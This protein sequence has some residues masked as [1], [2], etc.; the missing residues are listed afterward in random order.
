L[1]ALASEV[2]YLI[3]TLPGIFL[4]FESLDSFGF[5]LLFCVHDVRQKETHAPVIN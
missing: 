1:V 5:R 2:A 4:S 3:E